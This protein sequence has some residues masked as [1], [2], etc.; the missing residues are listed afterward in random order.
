MH[1]SRAGGGDLLPIN[2]PQVVNAVVNQT[3]PT[4]PSFVPAEQGYPAGLADPSQFNPLT[5][6]ITYMPPD[7]H[8]SPVQSWYISV[9]R[10]LRHNMLLD[11]AYVGNRADDLL[12]FANYN[13]AVAEQRR[14]DAS[15][16]RTARPE[17]ELR[18]HHLRL[19]RRQVA[20]QGA[21]GQ[22]RVAHEPRRSRC[23]AR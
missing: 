3:V 19:Q 9:Q 7:F 5:A 4:S 20:L 22:V 18:R 6:N 16:C 13:Q 8:S 1:F 17:P 14:R 15:R 2:G 23:S 12:L 10:E 21:A 11:V